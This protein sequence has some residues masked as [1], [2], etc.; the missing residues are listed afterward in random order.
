VGLPVVTSPNKYTGGILD[1]PGTQFDY[2][3]PVSG[4]KNAPIPMAF[5]IT[6]PFDRRTALLPHMLVMHVN[7]QNFN[8]A[9]TDPWWIRRTALGGRHI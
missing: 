3:H 8:E 5:Q 7:P 6:S 1:A 9:H 2:P 4:R